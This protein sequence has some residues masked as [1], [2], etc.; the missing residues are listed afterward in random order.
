MSHGGLLITILTLAF[1]APSV[2][3]D[4][5]VMRDGRVG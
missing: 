1:A 4:T 5:L 2:D 3:A